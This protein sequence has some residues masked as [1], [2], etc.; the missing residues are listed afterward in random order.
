MILVDSGHFDQDG[1]WIS[2]N[3]KEFANWLSVHKEKK[4]V[5]QGKKWSKNRTHH[6]NS[7]YWGVVL[8]ILKTET[9]NSED[10]LHEYL[11]SKFNFKFLEIGG[12]FERIGATTTELTTIEYEEYLEQV[13]V[14]AATELGIIIPL[15]N[16]EKPEKK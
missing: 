3:P 16:E 10:D 15:P 13:R 5:L 2:E 11:K 7:Y 14:W 1:I 8:K 9:G 12:Q 6:Q 4:I